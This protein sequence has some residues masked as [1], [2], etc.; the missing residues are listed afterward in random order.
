MGRG[1]ARR[2]KKLSWQTG[3]R[4]GSG[5][6][7][8]TRVV[9]WLLGISVALL[10]V[11]VEA[12]SWQDSG[13]RGVGALV[14]HIGGRHRLTTTTSRRTMN[15][16]VRIYWESER[17][18][19]IRGRALSRLRVGAVRGSVQLR[20]RCCSIQWLTTRRVSF[21]G[22]ITCRCRN[23]RCCLIS[24]DVPWHLGKP[25]GGLTKGI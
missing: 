19:W 20:A 16:R 12:W 22:G 15:T 14:S 1:W 25:N 5:G 21:R 7:W 4:T 23:V 8:A 6:R 10:I 9:R 13:T 2:T 11:V 3:R 18:R 24:G 17:S